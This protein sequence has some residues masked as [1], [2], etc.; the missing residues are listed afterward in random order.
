M[1]PLPGEAHSLCAKSMPAIMD[2]EASF[3]SNFDDLQQREEEEQAGYADRAA[4][5]RLQ[6]QE[7]LINVVYR[8]EINR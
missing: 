3:E 4:I 1:I 2:D 7:G 6:P 5:Y 8:L